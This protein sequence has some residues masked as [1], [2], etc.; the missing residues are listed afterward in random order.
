MKR[1]LILCT[2]VSLVCVRS[3]SA[4][5]HPVLVASGLTQPVAF[6][7]DPSTPSIQF[8]VEQGGRVRMV[9]NG[10]FLPSYFLDLSAVVLNSGERGLLGLAFPPDYATSHR[11]FVNFVNKA[12]DTVIA[13][14]KVSSQ[15]DANEATRFDLVWPDGNAFIAQPYPNHKGGTLA[16]GPDGY[17]YIGMGDGGSGDDPEHRAQDPATLL[18][19]MLRIDVSVADGDPRGYTVPA[20]NPFFGV[21][22]VLPEIWAFGVRNPWKFSFDDPTR[23]GTGALII[24]D[25]GQGAWEEIDYEPASQGGKNYGWRNREGAH[26]HITSM[27]AYPGPL[28]D[29]IH[30]YSHSD[31]HSVTGG[32]VYR[33]SG[34]GPS[35]T[36]RY[37]FADFIDGRI[38]SLGLSINP[39][40]GAATVTNIVEHTSELGSAAVLPSSFGV[41]A[42]GELYVVNYTAGT[43]YRIAPGIAQPYLDRDDLN[44]DGTPDILLQ[45]DAVTWVGAWIMNSSGQISSFVPIYSADIGAWKVV[46]RADLNG[47][48]VEDILLQNSTVTWVGAWLLTANGQ[49]SSFVSICSC[50]IGAW[51]VVG[52]TD[53]NGDGVA[54][55][56]MQSSSVNWLGAWLMNRSGQISGF[57]QVNFADMANWKVVATADMNGDGITDLVLQDSSTT[58][59]SAFL[60]NATGQ[61]FS[62]VPVYSSNIGG[63]RV[64]T[65]ADIN[66][67]GIKDLILQHSTATWVAAWTLNS[68]GQITNF[69]PIYSGDIGAWK[70]R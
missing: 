1:L 19:K 17:L 2:L 36:G 49:I 27:P 4:Q 38:W 40:T 7:Q 9:Y 15:F 33:G 42:V 66:G 55:I 59:V 69:L 23:G 11:F 26:V 32:Y 28:T 43:V 50:D 35:Y 16:F 58:F 14:F 67:D 31:G 45:N 54:D 39:N 8:I 47:D 64:A 70:V 51:K 56:I 34:L 6:V 24:G 37:F 52:T 41:D 13:R 10:Q 5:I 62:Q 29:P 25:V 61:P 22:G 53:L 3:A 65:A 46:G 57:V 12:G 44:G 20:T 18:G 60:M 63:W 21:G 68:A 30:E 48:G